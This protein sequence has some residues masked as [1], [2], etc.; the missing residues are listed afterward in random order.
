[1]IVIAIIAA[2]A[3]PGGAQAAEAWPVD[4]VLKSEYAKLDQGFDPPASR[5]DAGKQ[6]RRPAGAIRFSNLPLRNSGYFPAAGAVGYADCL[7]GRK[8]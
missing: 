2:I 7:T 1:M 5:G 8:P 3:I 4:S 6:D